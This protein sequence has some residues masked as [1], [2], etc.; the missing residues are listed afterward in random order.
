METCSNPGCDQAGTNKCS[1]CKTTPYCGPICQKAHWPEHKESCDGHLRKVGMAHLIKARSFCLDRNWSQALHYSDLALTKL[2]Q[3]KDRPVEDLSK[4]LAMKCDA[5]GFLGQHSEHLE[6]AKEWYCLWNTKPTDMG[7]ILA[8]FALIQS[9]MTNK[10]FVDAHLYASTLW[11]IINHKHDN[12][13]PEAQRQPFIA[14][15]AYYLAR[16]ILR[17]AQSGGIPPEDEQKAGHEAIALSRKA[18]EIHIRLHGTEN[19]DVATDMVMLAKALNYFNDDDDEEVIRL[20]EQGKA[21]Y[22]RLQGSSSL[23]VAVAEDQLGAAYRNRAERAH[24]AN[25]LDR[26]ATNLELALPRIR[27]SA[28]IYRAVNRVDMADQA[29]RDIKEVEEQLR[30]LATSKAAAAIKG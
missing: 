13:I 30:Q 11:E 19:E 20:Y 16:A 12:K 22:A 21:I 15:G 5:F 6:C 27:E 8:A 29:I 26:C 9:C 24:D 17:L 18:L 1:G 7:A 14:N 2:K 3:L 4:A 23:N 28:R 10:E 25:D